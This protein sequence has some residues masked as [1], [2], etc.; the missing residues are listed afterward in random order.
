MLVHNFDNYFVA[1]FSCNDPELIEIPDTTAPTIELTNPISDQLISDDIHM[2]ALTNDDVGIERVEFFVDDYL[3][4]TVT[5]E[6]W[7]YQWTTVEYM[8]GQSHV[9]MRKHMILQE[10][11]APRIPFQFLASQVG[12]MTL[13][14]KLTLLFKLATNCG[15]QKT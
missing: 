5:H 7:E 12:F 9:F 11:V 15:W 8:D 3:V 2:S 13:K 10:I 14:V 6:P 1:I 4:R